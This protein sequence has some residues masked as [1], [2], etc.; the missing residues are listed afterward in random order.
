MARS[1]FELVESEVRKPSCICFRRW[2]IIFLCLGLLVVSYSLIIGLKFGVFDKFVGPNYRNNGNNNFSKSGIDD[3][4]NKNDSNEEIT[5]LLTTPPGTVGIDDIKNPPTANPSTNTTKEDLA[6]KL[7]AQTSQ[8]IT[9]NLPNNTLTSVNPTQTVLVNSSIN[10]SNSTIPDNGKKATKQESKAAES[11]TESILTTKTERS[12]NNSDDSFG[13]AGSKNTSSTKP[14]EISTAELSNSS[15][16]SSQDK[17]ST[18]K[19]NEIETT[20]TKI[21]ETSK[22]ESTITTQ[23]NKNTLPTLSPSSSDD[24]TISST[25]TTQNNEAITSS[26]SGQIKTSSKSNNN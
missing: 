4:L 16:T 17:T 13:Q 22:K 21:G 23:S 6:T 25:A 12:L 24:T 1:N 2:K 20:S 15:L 18:T 7:T 9:T 3:K 19:V 14:T 26:N 10:S 11:T 5:T 8:N